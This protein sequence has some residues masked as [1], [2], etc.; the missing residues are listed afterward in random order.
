MAKTFLLVAAVLGFTG[1][2]LGAFGAHG[3]QA[4]L[5][6]NGRADTFETAN[7]YHLSHALGLLIVGVWLASPGGAAL[8]N[9]L[10]WAGYGFIAGTLLFSGSLYI[11]AIFDLGFMGAVAPLGGAGLLLGW[12]AFGWTAW[13][14]SG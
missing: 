6:A 4:A 3:L 10:R 14:W 1:V 11:L 2:A 8:K 12:A 7:R 5:E 9:S 13:K